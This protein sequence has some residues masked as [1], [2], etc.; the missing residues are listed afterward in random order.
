MEKHS[1]IIKNLMQREI[2]NLYPKDKIKIKEY[3]LYKSW[4][5]FV[6]EIVIKRTD[7]KLEKIEEKI[8]KLENIMINIEIQ[9]NTLISIGKYPKYVRGTT[10]KIVE[11]IIFRKYPERTIKREDIEKGSLY[12]KLLEQYL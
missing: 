12:E 5:K 3:G 7:N 10:G 4:K 1:I 6:K 8:N 9:Q 11:Q 2:R